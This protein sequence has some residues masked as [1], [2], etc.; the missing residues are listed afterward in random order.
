MISYLK[1]LC[2]LIVITVCLTGI[3]TSGQTVMAFDATTIVRSTTTVDPTSV[4]K[5]PI[6]DS[7]TAEDK[8]LLLLLKV[9]EVI[10]FFAGIAA[11]VIIVI[12]GGRLVFSAGNDEGITGGRNAILYAVLGL[13]AVILAYLVVENVIKFISAAN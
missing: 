2:K 5:V 13:L 6:S 8:T 4:I 7:A 11:V 12:G 3:F 10:L 1:N 9:I